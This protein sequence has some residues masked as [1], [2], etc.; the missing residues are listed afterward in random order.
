MAA[1]ERRKDLHKLL[2]STGV[3]RRDLIASRFV[4]FSAAG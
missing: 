1:D 4:R 3:C 2:V